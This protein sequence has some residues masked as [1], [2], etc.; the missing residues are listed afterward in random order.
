M[1]DKVLKQLL[2]ANTND[3]L[4][5]LSLRYQLSI[6]T[7]EELKSLS[8]KRCHSDPV[9]GEQLGRLAHRLSNLLP[10]PAPAL[11]NWAL[12][13]VLMSLDQFKAAVVH[14]EVAYQSY[15]SAGDF[16][17]A[18]RMSIGYIGALNGAGCTQ[19][20]IQIAHEMEPVLRESAE[21]NLQ[22]QL[23][24]GKL[25]NNLGLAYEKLGRYEEALKSYDLKIKIVSFAED[26]FSLAR[27]HLNRG[28]VLMQLNLFH[29]ADEAF[30]NAESPLLA[31]EAMVDLGKLYLNWG[32]LKTGWQQYDAATSLF[33]KAKRAIQQVGSDSL[34]IAHL[35]LYQC[36]NELAKSS[37]ISGALMAALYEARLIFI[38]YG[39][40]SEVAATMFLLGRYHLSADDFAIAD[41]WFKD[42][43]HVAIENGHKQIQWQAE[44]YSASVAS[45]QK[46]LSKADDYYRKATDTIESIRGEL[47]VQEFRSNFFVDKLVVYR[48]W[49]C[50][51]IEQGHLHE[52][53]MILERA[54]ARILVEQLHRR[55]E[56]DVQRLTESA[57]S[58][59]QIM[60][61]NIQESLNNIDLAEKQ[62]PKGCSLQDGLQKYKQLLVQQIRS[63][64]QL[65]P[66]FSP[67]ST[68]YTVPLTEVALHLSD[69]TRLLYYGQMGEHIYCFVIG[70]TGVEAH[71]QLVDIATFTV[72]HQQ[73]QSAVQ[74]IIK[75]LGDFG[76]NSVVTQRHLPKMLTHL[77]Q[78]L[79]HFGEWLIPPLLLEHLSCSHL[80][81]SPDGLLY[82]LPF[83]AFR[84]QQRY[85]IEQYTVS[86]TPSMTVL[87]ICQ[88]GFENLSRPT[89]FAAGYGETLLAVETEVARLQKQFPELCC[90][91]GQEAT[92]DAV[93]TQLPNHHFLHLASHATFRHD[94]AMLSGFQWADRFLTLAEISQLQLQA[95]LVTLSGCQTGFGRI[96]GS[97][98]I[99]LATGFLAAGAKSLLV[100]L[101]RVEDEATAH[102]MDCFYRELQ[103]GCSRAKALQLAQLELLHYGRTGNSLL[104]KHPICWAPFVLVGNWKELNLERRVV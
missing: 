57:D 61:E 67:L 9:Q 82:E 73:F 87:D 77:D 88:Q 43:L 44:Y 101:W 81:I 24:Y 97:D 47:Q 74:R 2:Q 12:G 40:T 45:T 54:R 3:K 42:A 69:D 75:L 19:L 84:L 22:D 83:H 7:I 34:D 59:I 36:G 41:R 14:Y 90:L 21:Y 55:F 5:H 70:R 76:M 86:Y 31:Y 52:G 53:M 28:C 1:D 51:Q 68:G 4:S 89:F 64:E 95:E 37:S 80:I 15:L 78:L 32:F 58:A 33:S 63:L 79:E 60:A 20:A 96:Q 103:N 56:I 93:L 46:L 72:K 10:S 30:Q 38:R 50:L 94:I 91:I 29:E 6:E 27:A 8:I 85:L 100:T 49:A 23:I 71:Y 16:L 11:G 18:A 66:R 98:L 26:E 104:Y 17:T 102:L 92:K 62:Q 13:N 48:E 35:T 65:S 25:H 99:S 39:C